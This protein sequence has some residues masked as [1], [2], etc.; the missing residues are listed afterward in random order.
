M[1]RF[2]LS[3]LWTRSAIPAWLIPTLVLAV[4]VLIPFTSPTRI[5]QLS[6]IFGINALLAQSINILTGY[7]GQISLGQAA[8]FGTGAYGTAVLTVK[9][10]WPIFASIPAAIALAI[11]V[12]ALVSFPAGRVREFYLAMV[13]LGLGMLAFQVMRQWGDVTGGFSG[14]G[15]IPSPP[16]GNLAIGNYEV[17]LVSYYYIVIV[18]VVLVT[19]LLT[20]VVKS[21]IGRS[22][23]AVHESEL[24]ASTLGVDPVRRKRLAY[25]LS[26][27]LAGVAGV[28]YAHIVGF[29]S[30]DAFNVN[31]SIGILVFAVLGGMRTIAGPF[32][33]AALLTYL[34]D[35]LQAFSEWQHL[36]YGLV[37]LLSFT[38]LPRGLA[39]LLPYRTPMIHG[40]I[41]APPAETTRKTGAGAD[42]STIPPP[43]SAGEPLLEIRGV[44]QRFGGVVALD[45]VDMTVRRGTIHGL[46]GPNGSGKSTLLNVVSG[47]Y[48]PTAGEVRYDG[49]R[50]EGRRPHW[51]ARLGIGRTFQH[52]HVI[53]EMTV[54]ENVVLGAQPLFRSGIFSVMVRSRRVKEEERRLVHRSDEGIARVG[55]SELS[56]Q[57]AGGL[58]FGRKRMLELARSLSSEPGLLMLDEPAAGLAEA[59]LVELAQLL[60]SLRDEGMTV[61]L[62]EHHM[63]FL[64]SLVDSVTVLD[65]GQVIFDGHPD[66]AQ[67][68]DRVVEAYLGKSTTQEE[69]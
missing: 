14:L 21:H 42:E 23:F 24:A 20:N 18:L 11:L 32:L 62:I 68:D 66:D 55:L 61:L 39:G 41:G 35:Q 7:A 3:R 46:I 34:P 56:D 50:T 5:V 47:V 1:S 19:W 13:T 9:Y 29:V 54:R 59:D 58:P 30:P 49:Q 51:V 53:D 44:L 60:Q 38:L 17:G 6:I 2:Q 26:A 67:R 33:G 25:L 22:L 10:D 63:D 52:P 27:A 40:S 64:L 69:V 48:T 31:A 65:N 45:K 28:T 57:L 43:Q 15:N 8:L 36:I 16:L 4:A 37:L 12:G